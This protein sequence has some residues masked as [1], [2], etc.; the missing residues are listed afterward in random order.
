MMCHSHLS[1]LHLIGVSSND[2]SQ[3]E[4]PCSFVVNDKLICA[5]CLQKPVASAEDSC[6]QEW[7]C[8]T[9]LLHLISS[10]DPVA[11]HLHQLVLVEQL[12]SLGFFLPVATAN[13]SAS[14]DICACLQACVAVKPFPN[15][16]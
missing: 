9:D 7:M 15:D 16:P 4:Q 8:K 5:I 10:S 1:V 13:E 3:F 12:S 14:V 2:D 11:T 6:H